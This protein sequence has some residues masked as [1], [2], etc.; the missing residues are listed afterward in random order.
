MPDHKVTL[1]YAAN[2]FT[3]NP[4]KIAVKPGHTIQFELGKGPGRR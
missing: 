3:A 1:N 4:G 2:S